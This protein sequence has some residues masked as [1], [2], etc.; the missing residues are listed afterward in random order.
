MSCASFGSNLS[1]F[2]QSGGVFFHEFSSSGVENSLGV[3]II[4][5]HIFQ[6][7]FLQHEQI[8]KS[9]RN[10][11]RRALKLAQNTSGVL[12]QSWVVYLIHASDSQQ[13]NLT[14]DGAFAQIA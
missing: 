6:I 14:K 13:S 10:N 8:R 3:R 4:F 12:A 5:E 9:N 2:L 7:V 11:V 1:F